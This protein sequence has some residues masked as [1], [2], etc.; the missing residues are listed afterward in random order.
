MLCNVLKL[1]IAGLPAAWIS[2]HEAA[3]LYARDRVRW[4]AGDLVMHVRGGYRAGVQSEIAVNAIIGTSE[5]P[6]ELADREP[7]LRELYRRDRMCLYC[8]LKGPMALFSRDHIRNQA[9]HGRGD[10]TTM[11]LACIPCNSLKADMSLEEFGR[12]HGKY[13]L[14]VPYR[15]C[16]Y[17]M[18]MIAASGRI[19][20]CQQQY[21]LASATTP[22][23]H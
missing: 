21:L 12:R 4:E 5:R 18:A 6:R 14:A 7:T 20:G 22:I 17:S 16:A 19:T 3:S 23:R 10:W 1:D 11:C 2:W 15:P 13:L 9:R 8:G